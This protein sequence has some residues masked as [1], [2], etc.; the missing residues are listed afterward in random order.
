MGPRGANMKKEIIKILLK[1][2]TNLKRI[3]YRQ[4]FSTMKD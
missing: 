3:I 1:D 4:D 2:T